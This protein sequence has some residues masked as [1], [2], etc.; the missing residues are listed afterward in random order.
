MIESKERDMT[1]RDKENP[2]SPVAD[3]GH[4]IVMAVNQVADK[5]EEVQDIIDRMPTRWT[6]RVALRHY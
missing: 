5:S 6:A 3:D 2:I 4:A 1:E